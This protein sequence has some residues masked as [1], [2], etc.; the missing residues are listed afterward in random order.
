M[1]ALIWQ[2]LFDSLNV[3]E[4]IDFSITKNKGFQ[5]FQFREVN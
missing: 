1:A 4:M 2:W 5:S 3:Q